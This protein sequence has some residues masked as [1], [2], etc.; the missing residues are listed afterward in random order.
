MSLKLDSQ[1]FCRISIS[2]H[3][4]KIFIFFSKFVFDHP[5]AKGIQKV[6]FNK[7]IKMYQHHGVFH[8]KQHQKKR[9]KL[10]IL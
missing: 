6:N 8:E 1:K 2:H 9:Q 5:V 3:D 7:N 4:Q 10:T